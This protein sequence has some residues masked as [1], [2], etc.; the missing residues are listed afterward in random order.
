M[1]NSASRD[2]IQVYRALYDYLVNQENL[3]A[4]QS[5]VKSR[6]E[7]DQGIICDNSLD[8]KIFAIQ[9]SVANATTDK[10]RDSYL[11]ALVSIL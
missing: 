2:V 7:Q 1:D 6:L 11:E 8:S 5:L 9:A 10:E 3:S 4:E